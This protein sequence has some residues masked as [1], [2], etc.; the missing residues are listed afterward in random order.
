MNK[1]VKAAVLKKVTETIS[2][3]LDTGDFDDA[4]TQLYEQVNNLIISDMRKK[5]I[6]A[7]MSSDNMTSP[8][9]MSM[10]AAE[11]GDS[12][13]GYGLDAMTSDDQSVCDAYANHI[14]NY[15]YTYT[16]DATAIDP[17][18]DPSEEQIGPMAQDIE[19]VNPACVKEL[20]DGTKV[21]DTEKLA[22]MNAGAIA[23]VVREL[24][25]LKEA[26]NGR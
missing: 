25:E 14:K 13:E 12:P 9:I 10:I 11:A 23:D 17:S 7:A 3:M 22:L 1:Y 18:I 26:L 15:L 20:E 19:Q 21:V 16:D 8:C 6:R 5:C 4:A 24:H 2:D